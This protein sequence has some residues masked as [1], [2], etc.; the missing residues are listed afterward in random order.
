M[1][2]HDPPYFPSIPTVSPSDMRGGR[3]APL[4]VGASA[5]R[6]AS[7]AELIEANPESGIHEN[8]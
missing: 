6:V 4:L 2:P 5:R 7:T 8:D 1:R 3:G